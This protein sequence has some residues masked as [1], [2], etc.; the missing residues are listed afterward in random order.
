MLRYFH[1]CILRNHRRRRPGIERNA[2]L[3]QADG[4]IKPERPQRKTLIFGRL[5]ARPL[6][7]MLEG[8]TERRERCNCVFDCR[9]KSDSQRAVEIIHCT[10]QLP[11]QE[12]KSPIV[13]PMLDCFYDIHFARAFQRYGLAARYPRSNPT[14]REPHAPEY[15]SWQTGQASSVTGVS[16]LCAKRRSCRLPDNGSLRYSVTSRITSFKSSFATSSDII[17]S[18]SGNLP[19]NGLR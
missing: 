3:H 1:V 13:I 10:I 12:A 8:F 7:A 9:D 2:R 14:A 11:H 18:F 6:H 5:F 15:S 19:A 17:F 4:R 16:W